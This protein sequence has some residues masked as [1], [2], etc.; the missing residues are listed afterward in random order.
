MAGNTFGNNFRVTTFGESHGIGLGC[1][2]DGC[3]AG[4]EICEEDIQA[5]LNRRKPGQSELTTSRQ[6]EDKV[7]ILSGVFEG[8]TTGTPIAMVVMNK[9]QRSKD[10]G[11]VAKVFRPAHA[12]FTLQAKFGHRDYRGGG[13]ASGRET[14][15]RVMAGAIAKKWLL[16]QG[17]KI[18]SYTKSIHKIEAQQFDLGFIEQNEVRT[19]CSV[20]AQKM[21]DLIVEK[22]NEH[23]SVGGV[24][25][26]QVFGLPAGIGS[27]VF[28]KLEARMAQAL[29]SIG[30]VKG[31]EIGSGFA[32]SGMF[33]SEHNDNIASVDKEKNVLKFEKN[34]S[35]GVLGGISTGD[36]M[37]YRCAFK[38]TSSIKREQ[39]GVD[40]NGDLLEFVLD[41]RHDPCIVP[42]A[43][44]VVEAMSALTIIDEMLAGKTIDNS[45]IKV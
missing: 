39:T 27:P 12:D 43:V 28:E 19:C 24:V 41:G 15:A 34:F 44:P 42:R 7:Q 1:V 26:T 30:S 14:V 10:Y 23:D 32:A 21:A 9:D 17:V 25:E 13:R 36:T 22:K 37:V 29:M 18:V 3:P 35:G 4:L 16:M 8:K 2:I 45:V 33:G 20:V 31:F 38:P 11:N 5:E 6:E 40:E